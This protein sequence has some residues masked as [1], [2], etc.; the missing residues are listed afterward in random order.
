MKKGSIHEVQIEDALKFPN[1]GIGISSDRKIAIKGGLPGQ[2]LRVQIF[3]KGKVPKAQILEVLEP[4]PQE[5]TPP[6]PVFGLCGGC[7]FQQIPYEYE[8]ELKEAMV[9]RV[10]EPLNLEYAFL[11]TIAA[12]STDGYRNKMEYSFGDDGKDGNL[13]LGMRKRGSFYEAVGAECCLLAH[14]DFA[15]IL[16]FTLAYFKERGETFHHRR[17]RTGALRHLVLRRGFSSGDIL[18][19]LVTAGD[20][21]YSDYAAK[22]QELPL[23]GRVEGILNTV[24]NSLADAVVADDVRLLYGKD[25]YY[26][27]LDE[28]GL[29][30]KVSAFSFFQT[31]TVMAQVLYKTIA[32]FAGDVADK[33]I[34][35]LYCGTGTIGIYLSKF[36][37]RV[38][39]IELV[40]EAV[41]AARGNAAL[42][43]VNNCEFIS[44]D[45]RKMV[46]EL[47]IKP[48]TIILDPPR[49]GINPR[50][51][52]DIL[53]FDAQCIVY[54][55]CKATSMV[56]DL[57]AFMAAGYVVEKI[58][59]I[60]MFPRT[61]NVEVVVGLRKENL[62]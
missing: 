61:A 12:Y 45:V 38:I 16:E 44:G 21:D 51:I 7:A 8:M 59:I 57:V 30:F 6:C 5:I 35:D 29:R 28:L 15:R 39:G 11:P 2:R 62:K 4:A 52:P 56:D 20:G 54:V 26:E 58:K 24:N 50:A 41:E 10:L 60:D 46:K 32:E 23:E 47:D 13:T 33:T 48:D 36:A 31:N 37:K 53:A 9:R 40:E 55:S 17:L 14:A 19:N 34:F 25:H 49:E 3:R 43:D 22:L 42:N 27:E 1:I 18:A